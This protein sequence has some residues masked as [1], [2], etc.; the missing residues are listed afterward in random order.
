MCPRVRKGTRGLNF[1]GLHVEGGQGTCVSQYVPVCPSS[2]VGASI[3]F[4]GNVSRAGRR[5][6]QPRCGALA[7]HKVGAE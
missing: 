4:V 2:S 7:I 6:S 3:G 1:Q 5:G